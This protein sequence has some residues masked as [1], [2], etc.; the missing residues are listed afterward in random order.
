MERL[1]NKN[2]GRQIAHSF[3][4]NEVAF[5]F[6]FFQ[7]LSYVKKLWALHINLKMERVWDLGN[8]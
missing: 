4:M 2:A 7:D 5:V 8:V 1:S 3:E 6:A